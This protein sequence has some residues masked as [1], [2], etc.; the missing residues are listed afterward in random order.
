[1]IFYSETEPLTE[2]ELE[3]I[4]ELKDFCRQKGEKIPDQD[5]EILKLLYSKK[6]NIEKALDA[7]KA[8]IE[9]RKEFPVEIN[10]RVFEFLNSGLVYIAGRDRNYRPI[11]AWNVKL[12]IDT[13]PTLPEGCAC[14][15]LLLEYMKYFMLKAGH[16]ENMNMIIN[17]KDVWVSTIPFALA[18]AVLKT[19][20]TNYKCLSRSIYLVNAPQAFSMVW[21]SLSYFIDANTN[22]KVNIVSTN[23]CPAML[24]LIAPNQ[25]EEQFGGEAKNKEVGEFWPPC[26]PDVDCGVGTKTD[27]AALQFDE[28]N[29]QNVVLEDD[30]EGFED[31]QK[32]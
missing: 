21:K 13:K 8:R 2:A 9:F 24:E 4:K 10:S 30:E 16:V 29:I 12:I 7:L 15:V 25:L 23:T 11:I 19:L 20:S 28:N 31:A 18:Q 26:L 22:R 27:V 5:R 6:M 1:M 17:L 14:I 3:K 32:E